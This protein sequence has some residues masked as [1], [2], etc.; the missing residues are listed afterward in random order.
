MEAAP[1][2]EPDALNHSKNVYRRAAMKWPLTVSTTMLFSLVVLFSFAAFGQ[3]LMSD[4]V[5][6]AVKQ[7]F[8]AKFRDVQLTEWKLKADKN[9]EA[10]FTLKGAEIA[11]KFDA[12]GKWLETETAI[13]RFKVPKAVRGA[14]SQKFKG[15][16]VI[17]RQSVQRWN[18]PGLIYELHLQNAREVVKAQFAADG[19]LLS[20]SAKS[21]TKRT[22]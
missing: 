15:Y 21:A 4:Q 22:N 16:A 1:G 12:T 7:G 14:A 6:A 10:E 2:S 11:A 8:Q 18:E 5:P 20:Q 17:E 19:S 3:P 13:S 9:Y